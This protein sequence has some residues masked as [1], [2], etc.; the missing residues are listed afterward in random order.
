MPSLSL[1]LVIVL[2]AGPELEAAH[3]T[4]LLLEE[5]LAAREQ[6]LRAR[7]VALYKL[8]SFGELPA[9]VDDDARRELL[10]RRGAARRMI[11]RDL[12]ERQALRADLHAAEA[13]EVRLAAAASAPPPPRASLR[14]PVPGR[15]VVPFGI[16]VDADTGLRVAHRGVEL[17][18]LPGAVV[19]PVAPGKVVYAGAVR[20]LGETVVVDHG[21]GLVSVTGRLLRALVVR[22]D[23]VGAGALLGAAAGDQIHLEIRVAGRPLDPTPLLLP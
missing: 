21:D 10:R 12:E 1:L 7:V 15:T 6:N 3:K 17:R 5:K 11:L 2:G 13:D 9:W 8:E 18:A 19:G 14:R 23:D 22:G 20:G 16:A 4:R